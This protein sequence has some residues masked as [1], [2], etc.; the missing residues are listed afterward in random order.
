M[1]FKKCSWAVRSAG[2]RNRFAAVI[3]SPDVPLSDVL[4][5]G[6]GLVDMASPHLLYVVVYVLTRDVPNAVWSALVW[7]GGLVLARVAMGQPWRQAVGGLVLVVLSGVLAIATGRG[8]DF[9]LPHMVR[10]MVWGVLLLLSLLG[11]RPLVGVLVGP[12][13]G[14]TAWR[15]DRI[16]LRAYRQCTAV[17]AAVVGFRTAVHILLYFA[18]N[19]VA[20]GIAH[21]LMGVPLFVIMM[22]INLRILRRGYAAYRD[23]QPTASTSAVDT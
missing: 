20:L 16:L 13:I 17:W 3:T 18:N 4:G 12:V 7:G 19:V 2:L 15:R 21:L 11:R 23:R 6:R 1:C 10:G 14:G 22:Y 9:Y 5:G 8:V